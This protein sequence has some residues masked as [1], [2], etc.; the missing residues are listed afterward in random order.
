VRELS[1]WSA[2]S[3]RLICMAYRKNPLTGEG[4][5][6]APGRRRSGGAPGHAAGAGR[7]LRV[8]GRPEVGAQWVVTRRKE[9]G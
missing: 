6:N 8:P 7:G 9:A 2:H 5:C 1:R 4:A 3:D